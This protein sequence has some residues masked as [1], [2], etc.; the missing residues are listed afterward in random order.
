MAKKKKEEYLDPDAVPVKKEIPK[1]DPS[2]INNIQ[3][4]N[5]EKQ[6]KLVNFTEKYEE[7]LIR[8]LFEDDIQKRIEK[9]KDNEESEYYEE[10]ATKKHHK[11]DGDWDVPLDE[12]I[13]YFD[14]ELSYEITGYRP[15]TMTQGLDFDP[16]P[17]K[18]T[19]EI[20]D[21][22][23][24]YTEYP[25]HSKPYNDFWGEQTKRCVEGYTVGKYRITGDHYFFLNFYRMQTINQT[26]DKQTT[27]RNQSFPSFLAK[28]YE[29][30]HY[31]E[32][33]EYL[34]KD[35]CLLKARGLKSWTNH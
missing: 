5:L 1:F 4:K 19:G 18:E 11:R 8:Q 2:K 30:F 16:T 20:F 7:S 14:P 24:S 15:I 6:K 28:Q 27:G 10:S 33:C 25:R 9:L 3:L 31:L 26:T 34:G 35:V 32:M 23:G 13:L 21:R 12:E 22:T 17:F 29:F